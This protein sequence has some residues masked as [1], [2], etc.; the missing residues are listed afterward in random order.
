[1]AELGPQEEKEEHIQVM[2]KESEGQ[3]VGTACHRAL[4]Q[5][6]TYQAK[7]LQGQCGRSRGNGAGLASWVCDLRTTQGPS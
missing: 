6:E 3:A 2:G 5:E 1:M 4:Q 7:G